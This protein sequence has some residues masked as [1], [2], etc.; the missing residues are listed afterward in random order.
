MEAAYT[1]LRRKKEK[2][3]SK[4]GREEEGSSSNRPGLAVF[5]LAF[6]DTLIEEL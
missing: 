5:I 6:R 4:V 3:Q 2:Q 1:D